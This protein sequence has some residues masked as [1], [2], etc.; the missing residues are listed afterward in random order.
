MSDFSGL[1]LADEVMKIAFTVNGNISGSGALTVDG[2]AGDTGAL[3][4]DGTNSFSG[5]T[6]LSVGTLTLGSPLALENSTLNYNNQGGTISFGTQ[7]GVCVLARP[8]RSSNFWW[9]SRL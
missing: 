1:L 7:T 8:L 2:G 6:T 3:V 4:L 5:A 9:S